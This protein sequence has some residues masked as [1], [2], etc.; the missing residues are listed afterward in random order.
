M[1]MQQPMVI[2]QPEAVTLQPGYQEVVPQPMPVHQYQQQQFPQ[3][4]AIELSI[5]SYQNV[6][7]GLIS[8][9]APPLRRSTR[10]TRGQTERYKDFVQHL[11]LQYMDQYVPHHQLSY[12]NSPVGPVQQPVHV[13]HYQQPPMYQPRVIQPRHCSDCHK[14]AVIEVENNQGSVTYGNIWWVNTSSLQC[15]KSP[16]GGRHN[17]T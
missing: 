11:G 12:M 10:P 2:N 9:L 6:N 8:P 5:P 1:M 16:R 15:L 3:P 4:D 7:P 14:Q 17:Q 13:G